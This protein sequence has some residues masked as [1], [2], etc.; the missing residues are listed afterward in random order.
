MGNTC[1][2]SRRESTSVRAIPAHIPSTEKQQFINGETMAATATSF[3]KPAKAVSMTNSVLGRPTDNLRD[4]YQLG[5]ELGRGQFGITYLCTERSTGLVYACKSIAKRKLV[6]KDDVDDV[7][8]EVQ[9]MHHLSG[10][11]NIVKIKVRKSFK[12]FGK[13]SSD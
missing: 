2:G 11:P 1:F 9:I 5:K 3:R 10:H 8:R 6:T 7:R 13:S 4:L 12:D